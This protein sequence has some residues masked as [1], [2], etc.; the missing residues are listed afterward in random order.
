MA[1]GSRRNSPKVNFA[2]IF[3]ATLNAS[4]LSLPIFLAFRRP[5]WSIKIHQIPEPEGHSRTLTPMSRTPFLE[6][7]PRLVFPRSLLFVPF[8]LQPIFQGLQG[9]WQ[10]G[11][12][13]S[14]PALPPGDRHHIH[15]QRLSQLPLGETPP[16]PPGCKF[17]C[18]HKDYKPL[19]YFI[20]AKIL[21]HTGPTF[22]PYSCKSALRK[23]RI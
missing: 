2:W 15:P 20:K 9:Q 3:S 19:V 10:V 21:F 4:F 23:K 18:L 1:S 16:F 22:I 8:L 5:W 17:T 12:Y 6:R 11:R 13:A 7:L 14:H